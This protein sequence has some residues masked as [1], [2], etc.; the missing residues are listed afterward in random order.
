MLQHPTVC[1]PKPPEDACYCKKVQWNCWCLPLGCTC[2]WA[3]G[4]S[5][6]ASSCLE[7]LVL[8]KRKQAASAA[9]DPTATGHR[10]NCPSV[11]LPIVPTAH[12]SNWPSVQLPIVP[13]GLRSNWPLVQLAF[14]P[15]GLWSNWPFVQVAK[16]KGGCALC[17][18]RATWWVLETFVPSCM[19]RLQSWLHPQLALLFA[20]AWTLALTA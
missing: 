3:L 10:S 17:G 11:Q 18:C 5:A 12:R 20:R 4:G 19:T 8:E 15:T 6:S 13:I 9:F 1:V 7:N 14:G 16:G 2:C